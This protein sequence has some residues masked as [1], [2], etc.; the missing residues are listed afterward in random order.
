MKFETYLQKLKEQTVSDVTKSVVAIL[1]KK[2]S[3]LGWGPIAPVLNFFISKIVNIIVWN[4]EVGA[5]FKYIDFR[6][7]K[8]GKE[9]F[10]AL[11]TNFNLQSTGT[12]QEKKD[13]EEKLKLAFRNL[14]K[15]TS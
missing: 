12:G 1:V 8:Q 6:V 3:W 10:Q 13:A 9:Y 7:D 14:V 15:F 11:V 4:T 2:I 5:Y